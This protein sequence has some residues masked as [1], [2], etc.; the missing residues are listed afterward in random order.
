MSGVTMIELRLTG[1]NQNSNIVKISA[2]VNCEDE[3]SEV[4]YRHT[5]EMLGNNWFLSHQ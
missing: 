3:L 4:C 1:I 5:L 2:F